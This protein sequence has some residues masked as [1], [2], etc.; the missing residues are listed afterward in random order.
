MGAGKQ[1]LR[2]A[3]Q[4]R[5]AVDLLVPALREELARACAGQSSLSAV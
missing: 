5:A 3:V 4:R 1:Y 2:L